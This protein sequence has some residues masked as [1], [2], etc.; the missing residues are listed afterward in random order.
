MSVALVIQ[1]VKCM[2]CIL[3]SV[4]SPNITY[5][6]TLSHIRED[7]RKQNNARKMYFDFLYEF[8][9]KHFSIY[10]EL[11]EL[12]LW[13]YVGLSIKCLLLLSSFNKSW[14]SSTASRKSSQISNFKKIR[15][16]RAQL[17]H[18]DRR[19]GERTVVTKLVIAFHNFPN[20]LKMRRKNWVRETERR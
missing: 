14:I 20:A 15:P 3:S 19:T 12:F 17:F 5:L 4:A 11:S 18:A 2:R 16:M 13:M 1:H 6:F 7:F 9:L 8:Y 10:Q